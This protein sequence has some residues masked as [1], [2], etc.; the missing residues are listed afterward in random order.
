MTAE[1]AGIRTDKSRRRSLVRPAVYVIVLMNSAFVPSNAQP[2]NP[3]VDGTYCQT[4][5]N[6]K[7][8]APASSGQFQGLGQGVSASTYDQPA[9]LGAITFSGGSRCIG[10][11]RRVNCK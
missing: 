11:L 10:L 8:N 3:A 4:Q 2:C 1:K 9:T 5:I 6:R 7:A